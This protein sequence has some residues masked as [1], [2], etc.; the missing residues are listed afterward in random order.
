MFSLNQPLILEK[1]KNIGLAFHSEIQNTIGFYYQTPNI[2][3]KNLGNFD[4]NSV[5]K[6][7]LN[8]NLEFD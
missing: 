3:N 6:I 4:L 1:D 8:E 7:I 5:K 2:C